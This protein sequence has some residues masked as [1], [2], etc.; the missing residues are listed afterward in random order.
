M[1][2]GEG[3]ER[4]MIKRHEQKGREGMNKENDK[5][6]EKSK[7]TAPLICCATFSYA[8]IQT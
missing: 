1:Q 8:L 4:K 2:N 7:P 5:K 6:M 3:I